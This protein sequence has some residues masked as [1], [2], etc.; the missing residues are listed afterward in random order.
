MQKLW[1]EQFSFAYI[2]AVASAAGF[3]VE[4]PSIDVCKVDLEVSAVDENLYP[5]LPKL[6]MQVKSDSD[7][8]LREDVL[9]YK[10]DVETYHRL[11]RKTTFT[12]ILV[13]VTVP[14]QVSEW[15]SHSE[16]ELTLRHCA[17]WMSLAGEPA[18]T[19]KDN[20]TVYLPRTNTLTPTRLRE[21][22]DDLNNGK[23]I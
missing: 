15:L 23:R 4:K 11:I 13:V 6:L 2:R 17:Y 14:P 8:A 3:Q 1:Q 19:N 10:L 20:I 16:D 7:F 21:M 18:T 9:A 22:M 12:R 5:D